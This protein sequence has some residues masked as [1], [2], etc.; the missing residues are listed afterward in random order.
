MCT[1]ATQ[2]TAVSF[3]Y[4]YNS[5]QYSELFR[6]I[7]I[8]QRNNETALSGATLRGLLLDS[9]SFRTSNFIA[10]KYKC[11][12]EKPRRNLSNFAM[13]LTEQ[14]FPLTEEC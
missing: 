3:A 13:P 8:L 6:R 1:I 4:I 12:F 14:N 5:C 2:Y 9:S 10:C 11:E 7:S